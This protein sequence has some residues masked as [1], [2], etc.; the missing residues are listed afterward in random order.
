MRN[1]EMVNIV[2][3]ESE[4]TI[5]MSGNL[6]LL[7]LALLDSTLVW[8]FLTGEAC[9]TCTGVCGVSVVCHYKKRVDIARRRQTPYDVARLH[10]IVPMEPWQNFT[11]FFGAAAFCTTKIDDF[12]A[13]LTT[14]TLTTLST[15][16]SKTRS[17]RWTSS[18]R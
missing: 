5:F 17:L 12:R 7:S 13:S 8:L 18:Q 15:Y 14:T 6:V 1:L 2:P 16:P 9:S 4:G 11:P 10:L 3:E